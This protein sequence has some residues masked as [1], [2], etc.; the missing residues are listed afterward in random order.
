MLQV[1]IVS[2][3][4]THKDVKISRDYDSYILAFDAI[5]LVLGN[6]I[7]AIYCHRF[8]LPKERSKLFDLSKTEILEIKN[9]YMKVNSIRDSMQKS[10]TSGVLEIAGNKEYQIQE[11]TIE[12]WMAIQMQDPNHMVYCGNQAMERLI[13]D[14]YHAENNRCILLRQ[15]NLVHHLRNYLTGVWSTNVEGHRRKILSPWMIV[16]YWDCRTPQ[17][18]FTNI[19]GDPN[20][21]A[22]KVSLISEGIPLPGNNDSQPGKVLIRKDKEDP[23]GFEWIEVR[24]HRTSVNTITATPVRASNEEIKDQNEHNIGLVL[25]HYSIDN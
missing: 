1:S 25:S 13:F 14:L 17:I 15:G 4:K 8:V 10:V 3:L 2:W 12:S 7:F 20:I 18:L 19:T 24:V 11:C 6:G 23:N 5:L 22:G 9:K 16:R 21:P